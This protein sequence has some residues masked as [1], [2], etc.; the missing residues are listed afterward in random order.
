MYL[1]GSVN[2][3]HLAHYRSGR[4]GYMKTPNNNPLTD[5]HVVWAMDNGCF[6]E[7]YP[8]DDAYLDLLDR[9]ERHRGRCLFVA[10]PDVVG[11][12]EATLTRSG[13]MIRR[14]ADKG[15]P[16]ALVLQ[17][18]MENMVDRIPWGDIAWVFVGGSTEWKMGAGSRSL[19]M[20]AHSLGVQV[21]V[22][23]VNSQVRFSYSRDVL[24]ADSVDGTHLA[25]G[26]DRCL[27][28]VLG[29]LRSNDQTQLFDWQATEHMNHHREGVTTP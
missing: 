1:S 8:G 23:R 3:R 4:I 17:D 25:F 26:P 5:D 29:W 13:P 19:T 21:H 15:W 14:I 22:G 28:E 27:P 16:V 7:S 18:G 12:A 24:G 9:Y 2:S 20:I 6:T 10:A 11:D